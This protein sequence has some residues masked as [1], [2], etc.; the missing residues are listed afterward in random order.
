MLL[1]GQD[2][3]VDP[4]TSREFFDRLGSDDKTLLIYPKMLHEPLNELGREQVYRRRACRWLRTA[5]AGVMRI[6]DHTR[7][8]RCPGRRLARRFISS[9]LSV[10]MT[11]AAVMPVRPIRSSTG[12][13]PVVELAQERAFQIG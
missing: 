10:A 11:W 7:T 5:A 13:G 1:G 4:P 6:R 8:N 9:T 3:V 12:V 2:P